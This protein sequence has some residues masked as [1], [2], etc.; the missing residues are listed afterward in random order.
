MHEYDI[1]M[2]LMMNGVSMI[3]M[4]TMTESNDSCS[5]TEQTGVV[6]TSLVAE[7][8]AVASKRQDETRDCND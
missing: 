8:Y 7:L 4:V 6:L 5:D 3:E 1:A 2:K